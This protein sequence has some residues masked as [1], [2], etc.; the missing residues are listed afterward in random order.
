[1]WQ[2]EA[3][4]EP[5]LSASPDTAVVGQILLTMAKFC[6]NTVIIWSKAPF[7]FLFSA[8][9]TRADCRS[10]KKGGESW[11]VKNWNK[12]TFVQAQFTLYS[13]PRSHNV[14]C[15]HAVVWKVHEYC[16]KNS[17]FSKERR[18]TTPWRPL[19]KCL[20][21][22]FGIRNRFEPFSRGLQGVGDLF[23]L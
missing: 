8:R 3:D 12:L 2:A 23:S 7:E 10:W 13:A 21:N 18:S 4:T 19:L 9:P 1:M 20:K 11:K 16:P 5:T 22:C 17:V 15:M 6:Y 14:R